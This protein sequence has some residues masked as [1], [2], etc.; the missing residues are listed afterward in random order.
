MT[1]TTVSPPT[2]PL[3]GAV[4]VPGDKSISHRAAILAAVARGESRIEGFSTAGDCR[5]TIAV[6]R[7]LGVALQ[8]EGDV[9]RVSGRGP[10]GLRAPAE[11]LHCGRSGT[12]MRLTA[13]VL[14]GCPF[15]ATLGGDRQL[16]L[17]PMDRVA[18]PLR[19]MGA[20]VE[21]TPGGLPPITIEGGALTGIR[22]ALPVASAQ[23]KS[24]LL[25][26]GLS[27]SDRTEV[28]EP[29]PSRDHT[30]RLLAWLGAPIERDGARIAIRAGTLDAFRLRVPGDLSSA[31]PLL[32]AAAMRPGSEVTIRSVGLNPTR[33]GFLQA[34][35]RMGADIEVDTM[36]TD[37]EPVG[38]IRLRHAPLHGISIGP[39]EVPALVD[40]LPILGVVGA[41]ADG[42]TTV[43]GAGE[44]RVKESD[45]IAGLVAG[46]RG[47]GA[48]ADELPDGFRV[49]GSPRLRGGT[50]DAIGDHRLS[51][52]FAAAAS[53]AEGPVR[54][55]GPD[56]VADSFPGFWETLGGLG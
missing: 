23:V 18:A 40:E 19:L 46:L 54:V 13:G 34:L 52:A 38:T 51:M 7:A 32:A 47:L 20:T 27:A 21:T 16:L 39:E 11:A 48:E 24:A 6:L 37:P 30:E 12:T 29:A 28:V 45:R 22:Y 2:R 53:A 9:V 1:A 26:A 44:L 42:T 50:C 41:V 15:R 49:R 35:R 55:L 25:L 31:A 36:E 43:R 10:E 33:A 4:R 17:R 56:T 8:E 3:R 5:A 14:A